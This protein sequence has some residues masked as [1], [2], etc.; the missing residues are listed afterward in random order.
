[1]GAVVLP[2]P[3]TCVAQRAITLEA[4]SVSIPSRGLLRPYRVSLASRLSKLIDAGVQLSGLNAACM[5]D[6]SAASSARALDACP[7]LSRA[8]SNSASES[9]DCPTAL[10][11]LSLPPSSTGVTRR[12]L[13][14]GTTGPSTLAVEPR[15]SRP[16]TSSASACRYC[17]PR[18]PL[19]CAAAASSKMSFCAPRRVQT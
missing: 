1:M 19:G 11:L 7:C 15:R 12:D 9:N 13:V 17:E 3:V 5:P 14:R 16:T 18:L 10:F 6:A 2:V 8:A 4:Q